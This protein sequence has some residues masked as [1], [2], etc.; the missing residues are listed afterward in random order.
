MKWDLGVTSGAKK[1]DFDFFRGIP[2][3]R[4][5]EFTAFAITPGIPIE[6]VLNICKL[7]SP[8]RRWIAKDIIRELGDEAKPLAVE[9]AGTITVEDGIALLKALRMPYKGAPPYWSVLALQALH[10]DAKQTDK[11]L[12][13][14]FGVASH[15]IHLWRHS[16]VYCPM[17]LKRLIPPV[18]SNA[19]G[20]PLPEVDASDSVFPL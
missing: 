10:R 17:T 1:A 2:P 9:N 12:A 6:F 19:G 13:A 4:R 16:R 15:R 7:S 11:M 18:G 8:A 5:L 14:Q 20:R 3:E